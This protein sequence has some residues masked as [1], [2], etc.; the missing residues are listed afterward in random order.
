MKKIIKNK[1]KNNLGFSLL[2]IL[3]AVV[4]LA[5]V[6]TPLIQTIYTSMALNKKSRVQMGATDLGQSALE[7]FESQTYDDIKTLLEN[8]GNNVS[9]S[10]LN[11]VAKS[12]DETS[13]HY[14]N[15]DVQA[16][17]DA[18]WA[19]REKYWKVFA[20]LCAYSKV[21]TSSNDKYIAYKSGDVFDF[22]AINKVPSNG[23]DYDILVFIKPL[24]EGT[25]Y[26]VYQVQVDVYYNDPKDTTYGGHRKD[27][28]MASYKGSIFNKFD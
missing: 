23:F 24:Y 13:G 6:V 2:E 12:Q 7:F 26:S 8:N 4:L 16:S 1:R 9:I 10:A 27:D 20:Q 21:Q 17:T 5:I 15:E 22:Y 11:Y 25:E 28:L 18:D 14:V 19:D 3:L